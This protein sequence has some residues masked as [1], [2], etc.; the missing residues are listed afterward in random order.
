MSQEFSRKPK[1]IYSN[2]F[3]W[4]VGLALVLTGISLLILFVFISDDVPLILYPVTMFPIVAAILLYISSKRYLEYFRIG[5]S[6]LN[7]DP[8]PGALGGDIAGT[9]DFSLPY[10]GE[11]LFSVTLQCVQLYKSRGTHNPRET[12]IWQNHAEI[13]P[14][15][16]EQGIGV[17]FKFAA[18]ASL[19][20][21]EPKQH[22]VGIYHKWQIVISGISAKGKINRKFDIPVYRSNE[23]ST[24]LDDYSDESAETQTKVSVQLSKKI[25]F[26]KTKEGLELLSGYE[27]AQ[28]RTGRDVSF[29]IIIVLI[30][31]GVGF[32]VESLLVALLPIAFGIFVIGYTIV[33]RAAKI[34][35]TFS[36]GLIARERKIMGI[37]TSHQ[38]IE[39]KKLRHMGVS[40]SSL[41]AHGQ[42]GRQVN[43]AVYATD[44]VTEIVLAEGFN[45]EA[46]AKEAVHVISESVAEFLPAADTKRTG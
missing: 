4:I 10:R 27:K 36:P 40:N 1:T 39:T 22:E 8:Y 7:L 3:D 41:I 20:E 42:D 9:I 33:H 38:L 11:D 26:R 19:P 45:G 34:R 23:I 21:T 14:S 37:Q 32:L 12:V 16:T 15:Q 6:G 25:E 13:S 28:L 43:F 46:E 35:V 30:G 29:G 31:I 17:S 2:L 5:K 44:G 24:V 18:P